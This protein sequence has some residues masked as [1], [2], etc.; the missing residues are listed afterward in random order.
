MP[1]F[2]DDLAAAL[3]AD[4]NAFVE[5]A[6]SEQ[7]YYREAFASLTGPDRVLNIMVWGAILLAGGGLIYCF[8][9]FFRV[10][11]IEQKLTCAFLAILLNSAQIALKL[12]FNMR[13]NRQAVIREI[14]RL[15][16]AIAKGT[17]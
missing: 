15:R 12:W 2:E 7:G 1:R 14:Y 9:M 8:W 13:L 3:D 17:D 4:D 6:L 16:L 5:Q 11:G 10:E